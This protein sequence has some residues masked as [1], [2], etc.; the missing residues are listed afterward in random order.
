MTR[1]DDGDES[2]SMP[3]GEPVYTHSPDATSQTVGSV[4]SRVT[5]QKGV[6]VRRVR[7]IG[8]RSPRSTRGR[9]A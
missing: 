5:E 8:F 7:R 4:N 3:F 6:K 9:K 2:W 1:R